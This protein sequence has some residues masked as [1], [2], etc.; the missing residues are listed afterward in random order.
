MITIKETKSKMVADSRWWK[1]YFYDFVDEF[2]RK[3]DLQMITE[4]F[5]FTDEK[6]DALLASTLEKLCEEL[7]IQVPEWIKKIPASKEPYFVAGVENLKPI[8]IV[9]TP[10]IF[11][12]RNVF[13]TENFLNRV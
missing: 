13:V 8:T 11:K 1:L 6:I 10:L 9:Q 4:P 5:D 7:Q 3:R 2:R 12:V